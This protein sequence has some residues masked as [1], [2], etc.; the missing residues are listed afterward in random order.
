LIQHNQ[1]QTCNNFDGLSA[2]KSNAMI[3]KK[4]SKNEF[5]DHSSRIYRGVQQVQVQKVDQIVQYREEKTCNNIGQLATSKSN[6]FNEKQCKNE[7]FMPLPR[8]FSRV[9]TGGESKK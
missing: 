4:K 1:Q 8:V 2:S 3:E 7:F 6:I 5:A 9:K